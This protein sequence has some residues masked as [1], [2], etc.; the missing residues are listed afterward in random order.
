[1]V[2]D[3]IH[4]G[5][6]AI[7]PGKRIAI[8]GGSFDPPHIAHK[9]I[10]S[11][12]IDSS[13]TDG[14]IVVPT[15]SNPLKS[16]LPVS[17]V[18]DRLSMVKL[19]INELKPMHQ[20]I[21]LDNEL[22]KEKPSFTIDTIEY[23]VSHDGWSKLDYYLVLGTDV[24]LDIERWKRRKA[25]AEQVKIV[26]IPRSAFDTT[27]AMQ[28]LNDCGFKVRIEQIL[29]PNV[30][31]REL[32]NNIQQGINNHH[33]IPE[34]VVQFLTMRNLYHSSN[35]STLPAPQPV[36]EL[37]AIKYKY[38]IHCQSVTL[39]ALELAQRHA[40][41]LIEKAQLAGWLHDVAKIYSK[42]EITNLITNNKIKI[43]FENKTE[44]SLWHA[45]VAAWLAEHLW[46]IGDPEI[47][48]A[49]CWHTTGKLN[50]SILGQILIAADATSY[51]R[52]IPE[53]DFLRQEVNENLQ[54]GLYKIMKWKEQYIWAKGRMPIKATLDF[55]NSIEAEITD[56]VR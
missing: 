22:K 28:V 31:A 17:S 11:H 3:Q 21:I 30:K 14:V 18:A 50:L 42:T 4:I 35:N 16:D 6:P 55:I 24:A 7:P 47:W 8:I 26:L 27:R 45:P 10:I 29:P 36:A 5:L 39:R 38:S 2:F 33:L 44:N 12:M 43:P 54:V 46:K 53:V 56:N 25:L 49:V 34:S 15:S 32:R 20:L 9:A 19:L 37:L 51:D 48:D 41:S 23:I 1:M 40:P 13:L 52:I